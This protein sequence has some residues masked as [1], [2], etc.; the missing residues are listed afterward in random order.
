MLLARATARQREMA[1]RLALGAGRRQLVAQ[2]L[3]ETVVLF[4]AACV[5]ALPLVA[6]ILGGLDRL[7]PVMPIPIEFQVALT[8]RTLGFAAG[9]CLAT[10]LLFGLAPARHALKTD[11]AQLLHGQSSTPGRDRRRLRQGLVVAQLALSLAIT[12]TGGLF[13]RSLLAA[14]T[15][16]AGYRTA[17][18]TVVSLDTTLAGAAGARAVT[19][20]DRI[21]A[22]LTRLPGVEAVGHSRMMPLQGA[23][24]RYRTQVPGAG[25]EVHAQLSATDWD[26]VSPAYFRAVGL[27]ILEGRGLAADDRDGRSLVAVVNQ[28]FARIAWPDRPAVGQQIQQLRAGGEDVRP[29]R[30]VGVVK[31]ARTRRVGEPPRPFVYVPF[32]QHPEPTVEL[33]VKH[34]QGHDV[35]GDVRRIISSVEPLLPV[36]RMQSFEEAIGLELFPQRVAAWA[37]GAVGLIGMFLAALGLY[38]LAAFLV[39]Q[40]ARE[41]AIRIALGASR[42]EVRAIVLGQAAKL[43]AIGI[44][45]GILLA[46]GLGRVVQSLNLLVDVRPFDP[47]TVFGVSAVMIAVLLGATYLPARRAAATDSSAALRAE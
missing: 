38:G 9:I 4:S 8:M 21:V 17:G 19:M 45:S 32:A 7:I 46:W 28:T 30:V 24:F 29:I 3:V 25:D 12:M 16:D 42:R 34:A 44:A 2:M 13:V 27:P 11:V 40:R 15:I 39:A 23:S 26:I 43:G 10:A 14:S 33:F 36:V 20:M 41:I 1:T 22:E 47:V 37:A 35:A 6:W 18:V 5:V 31:D